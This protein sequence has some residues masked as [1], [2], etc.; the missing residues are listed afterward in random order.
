MTRKEIFAEMET[1]FGRVPTFFKEIPDEVLELEWRLFRKGEL[2]RGP[3]PKKYMELIGLGIAA[4]TRCPY[5]TYYHGEM[6][7]LHGATREEINATILQA[8]GTVGWSA[9]VHGMQLD[10]DEFK[11]DVRQICDFVREKAQRKAAA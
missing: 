3:V 2:E 5:C 8:K 1:E 9:Y 7:K 4:A 6:A 11:K 10:L